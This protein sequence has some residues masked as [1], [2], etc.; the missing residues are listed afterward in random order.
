MTTTAD[1]IAATERLLYSG[2]REERDYLAASYIAGA[3]SLAVTNGTAGIQRGAR[4]AIG[5]EIFIVKDVSSTTV[6]VAGAQE[7]STAANHTSGDAVIVN[8]RYSWWSILKALNDELASLSSPSN[9]LF[10]MLTKD[11]TYDASIEGYDLGTSSFIDVY[12]VRWKQTGVSKYWPE[13]REY[14]IDRNALSTDFTSTVAVFIEGATNAQPARILYKAPFT[15]LS[16][17]TDDVLAVS[18]LPASAHDIPPY[19]AADVLVTAGEVRRNA[20]GAQNDSKRLDEVPT[21]AQRQASAG[22]RQIRE[23][24]VRE[25]AARLRAA[26]PARRH[27]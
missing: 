11:L 23:R 24:R 5:L 22:L 15:P 17:L 8:P 26:Y 14:E 9:G 12:E 20:L 18:G 3:T 21:G 4:L 16:T 1:L 6:T 27:W 25:E 10:Q 19:G 2:T 7:G 13:I